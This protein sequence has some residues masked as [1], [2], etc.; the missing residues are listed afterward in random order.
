MDEQKLPVRRWN[1]LLCL[2]RPLTPDEKDEL[3]R[4][5]AQA[6]AQQPEEAGY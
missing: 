3:A 2:E 1:E 6:K 5:E 4:I